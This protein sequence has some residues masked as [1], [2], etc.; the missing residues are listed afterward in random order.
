MAFKYETNL[1]DSERIAKNVQNL[2]SL[3]KN[4]VPYDRNLGL[5]PDYTDKPINEI[6]S[7]LYTEME[8]LIEEREPRAAVDVSNLIYDGEFYDKEDD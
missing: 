5:T 3:R 6:S 2:I 8:D 4:D 7:N 1:S